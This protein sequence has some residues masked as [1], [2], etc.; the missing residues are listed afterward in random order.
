MHADDVED[1][2]FKIRVG[3]LIVG[4]IGPSVLI[5][6]SDEGRNCSGHPRRILRQ[7]GIDVEVVGL[8]LERVALFEIRAAYR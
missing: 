1:R 6:A 2:D 5:G 3:R 4:Y 7:G 8:D